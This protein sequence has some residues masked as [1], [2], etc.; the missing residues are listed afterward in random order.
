MS[1]FMDLYAAGLASAEQINEFI[2]KWCETDSIDNASGLAAHLGMSIGEYMTF[3]ID[4]S[5]LPRILE[6]RRKK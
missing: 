4:D 5:S 2:Y 1:T 6:R 3:C